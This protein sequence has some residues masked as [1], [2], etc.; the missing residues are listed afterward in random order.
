[1]ANTQIIEING[2]KVEVDLRE[3]RTIETLRVGDKV[4]L[5][6][7]TYSGHDVHAGV[8]VGFEPFPEKPAIVV[9]YVTVSYSSVD[10]K[11][12][13]ITTDTKDI[14]I[15]KSVDDVPFDRTHAIKMFE[16]QI[17]AKKLEIADIESKM[18]YFDRNFGV[19]WH[20]V[21]PVASAS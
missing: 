2:V 4:K 11:V 9:A 8:I 7:K 19:Y 14:Q 1:M 3:A 6:K 18:E 12:E 10:L 20:A 16:K 17:A 15:I 5:L 13:T 21:V